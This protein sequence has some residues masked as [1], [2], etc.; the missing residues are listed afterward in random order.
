MSKLAVFFKAAI[1]MLHEMFAKLS[2]ILLLECIELSL[3]AI[4]VVVVALLGEVP[5]N[6][7]WRIVEVARS[8]ILVT[9]VVSSFTFLG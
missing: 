2:L 3:V 8:T 1:T 9:F 4:E 5:E 7:R 6:L